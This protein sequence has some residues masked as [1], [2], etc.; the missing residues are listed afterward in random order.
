M[1]I[2]I[3]NNEQ[4][5]WEWG[6][7]SWEADNRSLV[8]KSPPYMES[9]YNVV[10]VAAKKIRYVQE[11]LRHFATRKFSTPNSQAVRP[12]VAG[13]QGQFIQYNLSRPPH[14]NASP[15]SAT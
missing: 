3:Q 10:Y 4:T 2:V 8:T 7:P 5:S 12:R 9:K 13:C 14:L 15:P 6:S 11:P 1:R